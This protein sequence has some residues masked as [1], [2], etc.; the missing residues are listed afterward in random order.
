MRY[1]LVA[2][3]ILGASALASADSLFNEAVAKNGT[4]ISDKRAT[5][6]E[7]DILTVLVR[8]N[9][10]ASTEADTNTKK[11]ASVQADAP[12]A[13]NPFFIADSPGGLNIF[14]PEEL[15]NWDIGV[16][17]E[18]KSTG[19]TRRANKLV[20]TISCTVQKVYD[21]GNI[22]IEGQKKVTVNREDSTLY[23]KGTVR[24]RDVSPGNTVLSTQVANVTIEL[25]GKGPLWNNSRR[26]IIT[27]IL[28]WFSPF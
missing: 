15:P 7:G 16:E 11:D 8:E 21:N 17:N 13:S 2:A 1:G 14:N 10:D 12:P 27:K 25:K 3:A 19:Q 20:T 22:D 26:G 24:S 18:H 28:D 9:I 4:L 6:K 23:V 5:F